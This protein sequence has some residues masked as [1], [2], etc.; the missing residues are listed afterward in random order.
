MADEAEELS[1][2]EKIVRLA[3]SQIGLLED[4]E[5]RVNK[6]CS[7]LRN[8]YVK[9][10]WQLSTL[11][12]SQWKELG[13][14]IGLAAAVRNIDSDHG[15][16]SI[17]KSLGSA[18]KD[19]DFNHTSRHVEREK[20]AIRSQRTQRFPSILRPTRNDNGFLI[21]EDD[22]ENSEQDKS[23]TI[24]TDD[25]VMKA[26]EMDKTNASNHAPSSL[27]QMI[28]AYKTVR[29]ARPF[30]MTVQFRTA[31]LHSKSGDDLKAHSVFCLEL[32]V[33]VSALLTGAAV[34]M[35]GAFPQ[36][37][38]LPD[39]TQ[40]DEPYIPQSMAFIFHALSCITLLIQIIMTMCWVFLL[41]VASAVTPSNFDKF[42]YM[43][44][45]VLSA[46]FSWLQIG[47]ISFVLSIGTLFSAQIFAI[48][49]NQIILKFL[50]I[51]FPATIAICMT[52][53]VHQ[54]TSYM[55]R[56]A[57][58]GMLLADNVEI[59][60]AW[61]GEK[62]SGKWHKEAEEAL[63]QS[64]Y[65]KNHSDEADDQVLDWYYLNQKTSHTRGRNKGGGESAHQP[66]E[67]IAN[68][69]HLFGQEY[70]VPKFR[71]RNSPNLN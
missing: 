23:K 55:G 32:F 69:N 58:H 46:S 57:F 53:W 25:G 31:L 51:L 9:Y 15:K 21:S 16:D 68:K 52:F 62:T 18:V 12:S 40:T 59:S 43:N 49:T 37:N 65:Q 35:W 6:I 5:K 17:A 2:T 70:A 64:F 30:P 10:T 48:A 67:A 36:D 34:E 71:E 56:M 28:R 13:A 3:A 4:D 11:D 50:G 39:G 41:F 19:D 42:F 8:E 60:D 45:Y 20:R 14:P 66:I 7:A 29:L 24:D 63:C 22:E 27:W 33:V 61:D 44:Q 47:L 54:A 1:T 26:K 38:V